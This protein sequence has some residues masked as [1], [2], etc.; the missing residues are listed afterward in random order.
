[1]EFGVHKMNIDN[2]LSE[3]LGIKVN[4]YTVSV[5]TYKIKGGK[6]LDCECCN[7]V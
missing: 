6:V 4:L 2:R 3:A 7:S 1:M 5:L